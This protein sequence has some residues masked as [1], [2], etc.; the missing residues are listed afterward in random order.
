MKKIN[1]TIALLKKATQTFSKTFTGKHQFV[2]AV[3]FAENSGGTNNSHPAIV[4][5]D[6][7][8]SF[9]GCTHLK[10]TLLSF[11]LVFWVAELLGLFKEARKRK[12]VLK[13][14][15]FQVNTGTIHGLFG[16][17]GSGKTTTAQCLI[18]QCL[19]V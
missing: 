18:R 13:G 1:N 8:V 9:L 14:L 2:P 19:T 17:N 5:R 12:E 10:K 4:V 3:F 15:S 16:V 6:I 7:R 11:S